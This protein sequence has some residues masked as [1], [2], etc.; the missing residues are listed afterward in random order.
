MKFKG[1]RDSFTRFY[2]LYD[3]LSKGLRCLTGNCSVIS[4]HIQLQHN[5]TKTHISRLQ[6]SPRESSTAWLFYLVSEDPNSVLL[7]T[8]KI[9]IK[10]QY[11]AHT[12]KNKTKLKKTK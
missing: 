10:K 2:P 5:E 6:N 12:S 7:S 11:K 8:P 4:E 1:E 9:N 3:G